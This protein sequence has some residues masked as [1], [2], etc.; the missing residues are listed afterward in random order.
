MSRKTSAA[1]TAVFKYIDENIFQMNPKS[2]MTDYETAMRIGLAA[3]YPSAEL[4]ACWFHY[5]QAVV[6]KSSKIPNFFKELRK[7]ESL[8]RIFH[9]F[10]ALPLLPHY[11]INNA[12]SML[13][14]A[15]ECRS[16]THI[17]QPFLEYFSRQWLEKVSF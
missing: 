14:M 15:I 1:Y 12:F 7:D 3:V 4:N 2:F 10:L 11:E 5:S 17:F 9:K 16:K 6:K 13:K 8:D